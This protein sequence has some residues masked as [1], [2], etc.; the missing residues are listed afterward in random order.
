M[1]SASFETLHMAVPTYD[2]FIEP[3]LRYLAQSPGSASRPCALEHGAQRGSTLAACP[4]GITRLGLADDV[5]VGHAVGRRS[6]QRS[7][8]ATHECGTVDSHRAVWPSLFEVHGTRVKRRRV[9]PRPLA[10]RA[11]A[12]REDAVLMA[13]EEIVLEGTDVLRS[14][15][16]DGV[17]HLELDPVLSRRELRLQARELRRPGPLSVHRGDMALVDR[18]QTESPVATQGDRFRLGWQLAGAGNESAARGQQYAGHPCGNG[19]VQ[20]Q[21][22]QRHDFNPIR[23]A[24]DAKAAPSLHSTLPSIL[25]NPE[26][27]THHAAPACSH[28]QRGK[29][30]HC[31]IA[32]LTPSFGEG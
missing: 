6:A 16:P 18:L 11:E 5:R 14:A 2:Q 13:R 24:P 27:L 28:K 3:L 8:D 31:R 9:L 7:C 20:R 23:S 1:V 25:E 21:R 10:V 12:M 19:P 29:V 4:I 32:D 22:F 15:E 17:L 26:Q 30:L